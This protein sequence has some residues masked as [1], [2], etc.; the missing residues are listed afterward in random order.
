MRAVL[1]GSVFALGMLVT[2]SLLARNS[3][4]VRAEQQALKDKGFDPGPIDG[5][6]G[7]QTRAALRQFQDKQNLKEDGK[8]GPQTRD[9]LGLQPAPASTNMKASGENLKNG[10]GKGAKEIGEGSKDMAHEVAHGHPVEGAKDLGKGVGQGVVKMGEG[11][12]HAAK[13]AAKGVK[14]EVTGDNKDTKQQ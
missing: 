2:P 7:P 12:G 9:A 10:Y 4:D 11:T 13:N 6:D 8:L 5:L 1:F 3:D 14:N